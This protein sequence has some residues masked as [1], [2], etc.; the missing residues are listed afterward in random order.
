MTVIVYR[1]S[2]DTFDFFNFLYNFFLFSGV[3]N[4]GVRPPF[5]F[6]ATDPVFKT[7]S[8]RSLHLFSGNHSQNLWDNGL[9][10]VL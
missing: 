1:L 8:A 10:A 3:L 9:T 5:G 4:T 2:L 6:G 7:S